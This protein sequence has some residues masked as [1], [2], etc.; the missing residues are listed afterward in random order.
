MIHTLIHSSKTMR[1]PAEYGAPLGRPQLLHDAAE[2][3]NTVRQLP[4]AQLMKMM[5]VSSV[6]AEQVYAMYQQW[7]TDDSLQAPTIDTF[8]GDIYSGLQVSTWS[9]ADRDYAQEHLLILSGLYGALRACDGIMPY[10][11]EMAYKLPDGKSLYDYWGTSIASVLSSR[12]THILNLSA[13]EYTKALL[14]H[15]G[16]P[17]VTPKFLTVSPKTHEPTVVTVHTKIARGAFARWVMQRR[18]ENSEGM[19]RFNELGYRYDATTSTDDEP[20]F[21]CDEFQGIGL[22]VRLT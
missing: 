15:V 4:V 21:V 6:K 13:V 3:A 2:L 11:M 18:V 1:I 16:F 14:P 5:Q 8:V 12:T 20:V 7:S 17:V 19:K 10:R 9:E 22:S